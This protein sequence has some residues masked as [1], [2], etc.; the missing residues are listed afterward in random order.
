[1]VGELSVLPAVWG[2]LYKFESVELKQG[3]VL[4]VIIAPSP[5]DLQV[6]VQQLSGSG[7]ALLVRTNELSQDIGSSLHIALP[8]SVIQLGVKGELYNVTIEFVAQNETRLYYGALTLYPSSNY[9]GKLYYTYS[10]AYFVAFSPL[11]S[12]PAGNV[13]ISM[14]TRFEQ[15]QQNQG[16]SLLPSIT[17]PDAAKL[18]LFAVVAVGISYAEAFFLLSSY[19]QNKL[20]NLSTAR[21]V[22][23]LISVLVAA[24]A[25]AWLYGAIVG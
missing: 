7:H 19:F 2:V 9:P 20:S 13:T 21:K 3:D 23:A 5:L 16:G 4:I 8:F 10:D 24:V 11:V 17:L 14:V 1:M 15:N 12:M 22:L 25:V 18:I 6:N